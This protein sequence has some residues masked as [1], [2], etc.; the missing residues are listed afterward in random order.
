MQDNKLKITKAI[1]HVNPCPAEP[2]YVLS[3]QTVSIQISWLR[4][5]TDLDLNCLPFNI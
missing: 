2:E 5:P 1:S 3:L 4:K